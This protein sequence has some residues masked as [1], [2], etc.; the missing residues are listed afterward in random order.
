VHYK[1]EISDRRSG[2][3]GATHKGVAM[4]FEEKNAETYDFYGVGRA[5]P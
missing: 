1:H 4:N 2:G 5:G 3:R